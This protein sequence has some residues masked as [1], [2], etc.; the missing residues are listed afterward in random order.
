MYIAN[1]NLDYHPFTDDTDETV[2]C[3][4]LDSR[5]KLLLVKGVTG[6]FSFPKG[7]RKRAE[8]QEECAIREVWEET[9]LD[10]SFL[11]NGKSKKL[12]RG[13]YYF[14]RTDQPF[15]KCNLRPQPNEKGKL[16]WVTLNKFVTLSPNEC[17]VDIRLCMQKV[18]II[19]NRLLN[20][21]KSDT[22]CSTNAD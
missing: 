12:V 16:C 20:V 18:N 11:L 2:G 9:G 3:I 22:V 6:K 17:N 5:D 15:E 14:I 7:S 8:T 1:R 4:I 13:R 19:T 21:Y 10:V